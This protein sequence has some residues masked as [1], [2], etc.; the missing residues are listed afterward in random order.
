MLWQRE[1]PPALVPGLLGGLVDETF[2]L[3]AHVWASPGKVHPA[4]QIHPG[5]LTGWPKREGCRWLHCP[6]CD[7]LQQHGPMVIDT[8]QVLPKQQLVSEISNYALHSIWRG[9]IYKILAPAA[10]HSLH[11]EAP[12]CKEVLT[13]KHVV[14]GAHKGHAGR[15]CI[16]GEG[17]C[18]EAMEAGGPK[19][20][21][22]LPLQG[23]PHPAVADAA[24]QPR[25]AEAVIP[26]QMR[27]KEPL[28]TPRMH[29][30]LL[31]LQASQHALRG[32]PCLWCTAG[33]RYSGKASWSSRIAIAL[34]V[35][36]MHVR[37]QQ[38]YH[39]V[40]SST[41]PLCKAASPIQVV[42]HDIHTTC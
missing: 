18:D 8:R 9:G 35:P 38:G 30:R 31:Q 11:H 21:E 17:S 34:Y 7:S 14:G 10:K 4:A 39:W 13:N 19:D 42:Q 41:T 15:R 1:T 23:G 37:W 33:L 24:Q 20:P 28:H 26:V 22:G 3:R 29:L 2:H 6:F 16:E 12:P 27:H 36:G 40:L 5:N 32:I 25:D